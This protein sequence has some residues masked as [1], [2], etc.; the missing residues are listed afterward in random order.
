LISNAQI[1]ALCVAIDANVSA[2]LNYL[3]GMIEQLNAL[4][5]RMSEL[6]TTVQTLTA[7]VTELSG[8]IGTL[9]Q[10]LADSLAQQVE[11]NAQIE[12]LRADDAADQAQIDALI[13]ERNALLIDAQ[14]N[15]TKIQQVTATIQSLVPQQAQSQDARLG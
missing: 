9:P 1:W 13:N 12:E 6:D 11:L 15:V 7:A 5:A 3:P 2:L 10:Q 14:E 8:R 4:G